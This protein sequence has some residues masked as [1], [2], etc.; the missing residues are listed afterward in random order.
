MDKIQTWIDQGRLD[1]TKPIT[2]KELAKSK[3]IR[4][5]PGYDGVKLLA[6]HSEVL[7]TPVHIVV[8]RASQSAIEAVEKIGG[9]VTTRFYTPA[10]VSRI[11]MNVMHSYISQR[12]D[13]AAIGNPSILPPEGYGMALE[14][15][16]TG[17]GYQYRLPDPV[18]RKDLEYYREAKNRGYLSHMVTEGANASLFWKTMH[19]ESSEAEIKA[20]Q[21]KAKQQQQRDANRLW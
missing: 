17:L 15:R 13:P 4:I 5:P 7:K 8:S 18:G 2:L 19:A 16:V 1:P 11:K 12:W 6:S 14:D 10:A 21:L 3:V 9:T 20:A